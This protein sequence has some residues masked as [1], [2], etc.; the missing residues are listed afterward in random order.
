MVLAM[1]I[2]SQKTSKSVFS[3]LSMQILMAMILG[4]VAGVAGGSSMQ[5]WGD[6]GTLV[7]QLIKT[8]ATP[9][10]FLSILHSVIKT[11]IELKS[12]FR[13]LGICLF[14]AAIAVTIGLFL[15]NY[16]QPGRHLKLDGLVGSASLAAAKVEAIDPWKTFSSYI[17]SN[18]IDPFLQNILVTIVLMALMMGL[19]LRQVRKSGKFHAGMD[20]IE[21][22]FEA[23]LESIN[24]ILGW[25]VRITPL[26]V[27]GVVAKTIGLYGLA[28]L[29]GLAVY[30]AVGLSGLALQVL[31]TYQ[32]WIRM[33]GIPLR[34]F[35]K[36]AWEP[37][38]Y[39]AGANSSLASLP[40]T[41][42]A[43]DRLGVSRQ[44]STLGACV[45]TNL[46]NDGILLYEAMAALLVAQAYGIDLS[47][48]QQF[49][50]IFASCIAS[51]GIAGVPDAGIVSLSIVLVTVGLPLEILPLLL[52][53]DWIIARARSVTNVVSDMVVS[54]ALDRM[55]N[56]SAKI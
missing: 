16:F 53:V 7:I 21:S 50:V 23:L 49:L 12:G 42:K 51:L 24:V 26:A 4:I 37:V 46:N 19:G 33:C 45:G 30:V 27:F 25:I 48:Q 43:L 22:I 18:L 39:S 55:E 6:V 17:P 5:H 11:D 10:L 3:S 47:L 15:S 40:M 13:M 14:N 1:D 36:C 8:V 44:A 32:I 2:S 31:V 9:L 41:L 52:T 56:K 38:V 54:I 29:K 20:S 28:P 34:T 35:W